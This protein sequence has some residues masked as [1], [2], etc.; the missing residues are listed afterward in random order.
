VKARRGRGESA[1]YKKTRRW[2]SGDGHKEKEYWVAAVSEGHDSASG[3]R[4]RKYIYCDTKA[5]AQSQLVQYLSKHGGTITVAR[6]RPTLA[7][8]VGNFLEDVRAT[9][10][11][12]TARSYEMVLRLHVLPRIGSLRLGQLDAIKVQRLYADLRKAKLSSSLL[13]RVHV[14]L[15][16]VLNV[17]KKRGFI[18]ASPMEQVD[19]PRHKRATVKAMTVAQIDALLEAAK[20]HR[21]E[22]LFVVAATT[23]MRQGELF[24]L[25]WDVVDLENRRLS[26]TDSVEEIAGELRIVGTKSD[27]SSRPVEL[28]K[29]AV[30]AL[31]RREAIAKRE[32]HDSPYVF[33]SPEGTLLRKSNFLRRVFYPLRTAAQIPETLTFHS[34]R[35]SAASMLMLQGVSPRVVQELLGHSDVRLTLQTYSHVLPTLQRQAADAL[36]GLLTGRAKTKRAAAIRKNGGTKAA[37]KSKARKST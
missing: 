33:P 10:S 35:H 21:L 32:G 9:R 19:P 4:Q 25:R 3:K 29:L 22:A 11:G 20:G 18:P 24:A 27:S 31:R 37:Q 15:R 23:G 30:K 13:A 7:S 2:K 14:T 17:A 8:F 5:E 16:R 6:G 12:N 1:I 28:S 26:V 36:D 34:L